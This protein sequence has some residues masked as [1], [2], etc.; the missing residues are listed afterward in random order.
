MDGRMITSDWEL[1]SI[2]LIALDS[3]ILSTILTQ[4]P[5]GQ[6]NHHSGGLPRHYGFA[7]SMLGNQKNLA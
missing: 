5:V 3:G 7:W 1:Y 6:V 4:K 2:C